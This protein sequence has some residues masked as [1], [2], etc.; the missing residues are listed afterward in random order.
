MTRVL[1]A[2]T[3]GAENQ[4][5]SICRRDQLPFQGVLSVSRRHFPTAIAV[6]HTCVPTHNAN[7]PRVL[8]IPMSQKCGL[9]TVA[10]NTNDQPESVDEPESESELSVFASVSWSEYSSAAVSSSISLS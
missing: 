2:L 1:V 4:Q 9:S 10:L 6:K 3:S 8:A 5:I 7:S